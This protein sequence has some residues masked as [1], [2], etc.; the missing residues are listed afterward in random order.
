M[1]V[2]KLIVLITLISA[3]QTKAQ[4]NA[5]RV[6]TLFSNVLDLSDAKLNA[7]RPIANINQ[8]AAHQADTILIVNKANAKEVFDLAKQYKSCIISVE[9]HT[10]VLIESWKDCK[11]SGSWSYCMPKGKGFIQRSGE[12]SE[13]EDYINN[14]IGIPNTQRRTVFL[15][16]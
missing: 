3:T 7:D 8:L 4:T 14:I 6:S 2:L 1:K 15:F 5:D 11:A 12:V 9:R 13:K 16:K 10:V